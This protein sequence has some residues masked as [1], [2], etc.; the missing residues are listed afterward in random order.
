MILIH[1]KQLWSQGNVTLYVHIKKKFSKN[2]FL[3]RE[4]LAKRVKIGSRSQNPETQHKQMRWNGA[5]LVAASCWKGHAAISTSAKL[6]SSSV[7][8][9]TATG[10]LESSH[11]VH[12]QCQY[13]SII[14]NVGVTPLKSFFLL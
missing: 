9:S 11:V 1:I 2:Q 14:S 12:L 4:Q 6:R 13:Q 5:K 10:E 7:P 3:A 8:S